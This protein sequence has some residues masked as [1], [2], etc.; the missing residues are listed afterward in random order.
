MT[1]SIINHEK[2]SLSSKISS[3]L[4]S[5]QQINKVKHNT[6]KAMAEQGKRI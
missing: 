2:L 1:K 6:T 4:I 5:T 3:D